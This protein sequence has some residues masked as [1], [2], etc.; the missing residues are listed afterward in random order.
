MLKLQNTEDGKT[1]FWAFALSKDMN[2]ETLQFLFVG[3]TMS[4][5]EEEAKLSGI[6][7]TK[8]DNTTPTFLEEPSGCSKVVNPK[9]LQRLMTLYEGHQAVKMR[10]RTIARLGL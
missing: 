7:F 9:F 8:H 2:P 5:K 6:E 1:D 10:K 4:H 3:V